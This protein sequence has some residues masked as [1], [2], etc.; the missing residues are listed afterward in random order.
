FNMPQLDGPALIRELKRI[1]P[2]VRVVLIAGYV[3]PEDQALAAELGVSKLLE[4]PQSLEDL[5]KLVEQEL[6]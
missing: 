1:R 6:S 4:K 5:A 2:D 3:R